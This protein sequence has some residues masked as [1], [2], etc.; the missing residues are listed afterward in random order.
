MTV[1]CLTVT[2]KILRHARRRLDV[3][4]MSFLRYPLVLLG[5]NLSAVAGSTLFLR[6]HH[7]YNLEEHEARMDEL[8]GMYILVL[9]FLDIGQS[10]PTIAFLASRPLVQ[11]NADDSIFADATL[12]QE[13]YGGTSA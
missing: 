6:S 3:P 11:R 2:F 8:E 5:I 9:V 1:R 12:E 7:V 4:D 13:P 10:P